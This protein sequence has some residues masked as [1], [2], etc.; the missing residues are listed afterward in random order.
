MTRPWYW[1]AVCRTCDWKSK[2]F[3]GT[4][5]GFG[6]AV[7]EEKCHREETTGKDRGRILSHAVSLEGGPEKEEED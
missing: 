1:R 7:K 3:L 6:A 4:H 2:Q 5:D